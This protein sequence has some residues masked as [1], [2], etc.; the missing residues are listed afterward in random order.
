MKQILALICLAIIVSQGAV[1]SAAIEKVTE[2]RGYI[3]SSAEKYKDVYPNVA[4]ISFTKE[5]TEKTIELAS[6]KN[7]EVMA[8]ITKSLQAYKNDNTEIK[9]ELHLQ[10]QKQKNSHGLHGCKLNY[11]KNQ[12]YRKTRKND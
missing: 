4:E 3:S 8:E 9:P 6:T 7:K 1:Y 11:G 2:E 5:T 10:Q 12:R